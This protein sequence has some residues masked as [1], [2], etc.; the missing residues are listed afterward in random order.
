MIINNGNIQ[1]II[2][3]CKKGKQFVV[4]KFV[5]LMRQT[6][7]VGIFLDVIVEFLKKRKK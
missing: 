1:I 3:M 5:L 7:E 6:S 2:K 4:E